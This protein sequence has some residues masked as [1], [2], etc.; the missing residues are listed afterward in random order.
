MSQ[1]KGAATQLLMQFE[2]AYRTAPSPA[3]AKKMPF[4]TWE[5]GADFRRVKDPTLS[6]SPLPSKSGD[7]GLVV[8]AKPFTGILDLRSIGYWL[9]L[10]LGAPTTTGT[11]TYTH[12]F[13]VNLTERPSALLEM[14]F[15]DINQ[16]Y[17]LLGAK[18]KKL[19]W[20][21]MAD[22]QMMSG[23]ILAATET[24]VQ[25]PFDASP[26]AVSAARSSKALTVINDGSGNTLGQV[27]GGTI[28]FDNQMTGYELA[29]GQ[30]GYGIIDQGD[31]LIAGTLSCVFDGA[32]AYALARA[33]TSTR[34]KT[35]SSVVVGA[36]TFTLTVDMPYVELAEPKRK[37]AGKSGV[38]ADMS[39]AAHAGA[40]LPTI[41]LV[42]DVPGY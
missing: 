27:T 20:D 39:W 19:S 23:E 13:P 29:D 21:L 8:P 42:N 18:L 3:A 5:P 6:A 25:A 7:G 26:T 41:T 38:F 9:K 17:R 1:A 31:L 12:V 28:A 10:L 11:S 14:G 34:L 16:Y 30:E 24:N 32:G 33:G 2:T 4:V 22:E 37:I 40:T 36:A 15:T 35:V